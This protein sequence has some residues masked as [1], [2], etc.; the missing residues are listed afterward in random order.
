MLEKSILSFAMYTIEFSQEVTTFK[1]ARAHGEAEFLAHTCPRVLELLAFVDIAV[2]INFC[3]RRF[4]L[5]RLQE[6]T[7]VTS[8]ECCGCSWNVFHYSHDL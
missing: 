7:S 5:H 6:Y 2:Y 1:I 4:K 8:R 3:Q